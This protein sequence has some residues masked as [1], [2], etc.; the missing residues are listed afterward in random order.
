M[1]TSELK[2]IKITG[3]FWKHFIDVNRA[4][5]IP[6]CDRKNEDTGRIEALKLNW[7]DGEPN[8]PH[9]FWDSDVAKWLEA[10]AYSLQSFPDKELEAKVDWIIALVAASQD[11]DGYFNSYFQ[12]IEPEQRWQNLRDMHELYCG[13]H[14]MEAAVA[15][16]EATGKD[17]LLR[18]MIRYADYIKSVFGSS[19]TQRHGYPG[20]EEIE[21]ALVKMAQA[22]GNDD[23][24]SLARFF[25]Y[26]RGAEP[27]Y[28]YEVERDCV[29]ESHRASYYQA[30][31]PVVEQDEAVGHAVRA[32]YLYTAMADL[33]RID[34]DRKLTSACKKLWRNIVDKKL[35]VTGGIG[36]TYAGEAFTS[37][38]DL[39]NEEAYAE[40]CA[41][42]GLIFF[43]YRMFLLEKEAEY[44]DVLELALYNGAMSGAS[45]DGERFF[46]VNPLACDPSGTLANGKRLEPRP[47]WFGCSC[48]PP[49]VARLRASL[50]QYFYECDQENIWINLYN[51]NEF[52]H[53]IGDTPVV[54]R[55]ET[56]YP[57]CG[58]I[59]ITVNP[60][61]PVKLK[62]HLRIPQ[63]CESAQLSLN[64]N[65]VNLDIDN[66]YAV[67]DRA[68]IAG[69]QLELNL[70]MPVQM[71]YANPKVRHDCGRLALQRG[72]L[73]YCLEEV[74]NGP[75][76]NTIR[77]PRNVVF[78][79]ET[80]NDLLNGVVTLTADAEKQA[81]PSDEKL[82]STVRPEYQSCRIKAVPYYAWGNR[83]F[84]EMLV[85]IRAD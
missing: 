75:D 81:Q 63:W 5:T 35:Y 2:K 32:V 56:N 34:D 13:G 80:E 4:N 46:Y 36:S 48:C 70:D 55:Q 62:L 51:E 29:E 59:K 39:P 67:L 66:G 60:A 77:I 50:G 23:Y 82:Y 65:G 40:T 16:Y 10:A 12:Q 9:H 30:H 52:E 31:K 53:I 28:F 64:D 27:H 22:T 58:K 45:L 85:W 17:S 83:R 19:E 11:S 72:P 47:E 37:E 42:I 44:I 79:T 76:L 43:A 15:Y 73:V 26:E 54:L 61:S 68:W 49:N 84:G 6:A 3:G 1:Q 25:V 38:Y 14:L 78:E 41:A 8:K 21:L 7:H 20:H 33:A 57:W 24:L 71:V 69:D 18:V 74:D